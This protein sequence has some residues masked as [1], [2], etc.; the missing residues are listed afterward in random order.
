MRV[1]LGPY[2]TAGGAYRLAKALRAHGID[3][4]SAAVARPK[5]GVL[6]WKADREIRWEGRRWQQHL[7]T[8]TH[9]LM[10]SGLSL[11]GRGRWFDQDT[12]PGH[13]AIV[14]TGSELRQPLVHKTLDAASPYGDDVLSRKL[15]RTSRR[16]LA[17]YRR[18]PLP[19]F[20]LNADLLDYAPGTWL[21]IIGSPMEAPPIFQRQRPKILYAPTNR[22]LKGAKYVDALEQKGFDLIH[23]ERM[24]SPETMKELLRDADML[25][26]GLCIGDYG[27]TEVQALATGRLVITN[28]AERVVERMPARPPFVHATPD[29]LASVI[30]DVLDNRDHYRTVAESGREFWE[31]YHDGRY[32]VQQ[33]QGFL[34]SG[35]EPAFASPRDVEYAV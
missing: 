16:W 12:L 24:L 3:A 27:H 14:A 4:E 33:L 6:Q 22:L 15:I 21:P 35:Q 23:P 28:I 26:G 13:E 31:R 32:S 30:A 20:V 9:F 5:L 25:I 7:E 2:N 19:L 11:K 8:F 1:L 29:T 17:R 18:R 34:Q 10:W